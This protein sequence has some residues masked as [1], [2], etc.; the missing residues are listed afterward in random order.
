MIILGVTLVL[1][2]TIA[3][4]YMY[5]LHRDLLREY[6]GFSDVQEMKILLTSN[7]LTLNVPVMHAVVMNNDK[8]LRITMSSEMIFPDIK[9]LNFAQ[10][11]KDK[12][13]DLVFSGLNE[14]A[15][16]APKKIIDD[17]E[18]LSARI[19]KEITTYYINDAFEFKLN[20]R[21]I[22]LRNNNR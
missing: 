20:I 5:F 19:E 9:N 8:N 15:V 12:I 4:G 1:V 6:L 10:D 11:R 7:Q 14:F 13:Y 3:F 17:T 21:K 16:K 2:V 18:I 22:N